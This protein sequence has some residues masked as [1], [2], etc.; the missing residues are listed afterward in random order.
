VKAVKHPSDGDEAER[1]AAVQI[2]SVKVAG[3]FSEGS[4]LGGFRVFSAS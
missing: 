4:R 1:E 2:F 3:D